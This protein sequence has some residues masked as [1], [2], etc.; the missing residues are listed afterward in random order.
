VAVAMQVDRALCHAIPG[1]ERIMTEHEASAFHL[2]FSIMLYAGPVEF[3]NLRW[4]VIPD[5]KVLA[6]I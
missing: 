5:N 1:P 2:R 4:I 3:Q 6:A